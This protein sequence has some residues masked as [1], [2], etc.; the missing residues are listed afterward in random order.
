MGIST[1]VLAILEDKRAI[2][3]SGTQRSITARFLPV[4]IAR[5]D[6]F[7]IFSGTTFQKSNRWS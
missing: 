4:L 3:K 2:T 7:L 5:L 1:Q 6:A